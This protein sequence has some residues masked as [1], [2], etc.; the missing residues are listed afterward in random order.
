MIQDRLTAKFQSAK[1]MNVAAKPLDHC[2]GSK[3][4]GPCIGLIDQTT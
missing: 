1:L 3:T 2:S 4:C